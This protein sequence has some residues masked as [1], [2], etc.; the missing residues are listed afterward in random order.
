VFEAM[1]DQQLGRGE[2]AREAYDR[3]RAWLEANRMTL[4]ATPPLAAELKRW[5]VEAEKLF[6]GKRV[7]N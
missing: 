1:A 7:A 2:A 6:G 5:R 3:A 4:A